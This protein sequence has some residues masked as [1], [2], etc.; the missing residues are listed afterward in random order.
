MIKKNWNLNLNSENVKL[1]K[2]YGKITTLIF[3][4]K[5][6]KKSNVCLT[7]IIPKIPKIEK[8]VRKFWYRFLR[9]NSSN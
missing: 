4:R 2:K 8:K 3:L 1:L 6:R 5:N 9:K 7:L